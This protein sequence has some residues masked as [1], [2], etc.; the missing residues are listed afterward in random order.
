MLTIVGQGTNQP[1][2]VNSE[3]VPSPDKGG[4]GVS[5]FEKIHCVDPEQGAAEKK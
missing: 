4:E 1:L 5:G 3:L 2:R